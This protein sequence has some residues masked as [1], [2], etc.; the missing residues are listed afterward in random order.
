M[1]DTASPVAVAAT[2]PA[3]PRLDLYAPIHKALRLFMHD[4][5]Q[6]IGSMDSADPGELLEALAQLKRLLGVLRQH[7]HHENE[8]MHPA[9]EARRP[10][11][12]QRAGEDHEEH[13]A[14]I[15]ALEAEATGLTRAAAPQ[16][17]AL[18]LRLYRHLA[19]FVA[20][21]LQHMQL[22]E[23]LHNQQLWAAYS[24]AE[25]LA[26]H[27]RLVASIPPAEMG[28]V[29]HWMV[30]ALSPAE[31]S[32]MLMG[33]RAEMPAPAFAG[34]LDLVRERL[35]LERWAKLDAAL[36]LVTRRQAA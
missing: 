9:L 30:P 2:A 16:R 7:L 29:L 28:L 13:L 14:A 1:L 27:Q 31:L 25:L 19:L 12:S 11:A 3:A 17:E 34:V 26:L 4:T 10:G 35:T 20:E 5:L 18:A 6:R 23:S 24:D 22:E 33:M 36:G 32:G 8:F 15:E 21:N